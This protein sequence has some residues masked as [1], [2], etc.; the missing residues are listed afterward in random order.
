MYFCPQTVISIILY[1]YY[2]LFTPVTEMYLIPISIHVVHLL[3]VFRTQIAWLI[4]CGYVI[5]PDF[6][7]RITVDG[8]GV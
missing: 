5:R 6:V 3:T 4:H 2:S 7:H 1:Q 8:F